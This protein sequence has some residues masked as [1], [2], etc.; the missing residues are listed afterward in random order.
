MIF[1]AFQC[2]IICLY[3][4]RI[5]SG[6]VNIFG[7]GAILPLMRLRWWLIWRK[8]GSS[9]IF[10]AGKT[11]GNSGMKSGVSEV[12]IAEN[13][14]L[15]PILQVRVIPFLGN[16]MIEFPQSIIASWVVRYGIPR[17]MS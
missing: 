12:V 11:S 4:G 3:A 16:E 9:L 8:G 6:T 13:V 17:N 1:F 5:L 15:F 2:F 7:L 10:L 14:A